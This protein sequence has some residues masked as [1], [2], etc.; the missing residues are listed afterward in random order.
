MITLNPL[1]EVGES[2]VNAGDLVLLNLGAGGLLAIALRGEAGQRIYAALR[3]PGVEL[4]MIYEARR[5]HHVLS[6]GSETVLEVLPSAETALSDANHGATPGMMIMG[7][8]RRTY[9]RCGTTRAA[10]PKPCS[11]T[12]RNGSSLLLRPLKHTA[13]LGASGPV[14][15]TAS[16][17]EPSRSS[18]GHR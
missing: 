6:Y 13:S 7:G 3:G 17:Q 10:S 15:V 9:W 14:R 12:L 1:R 8:G 18:S 5:Q 11:T 2:K 4:P 16:A